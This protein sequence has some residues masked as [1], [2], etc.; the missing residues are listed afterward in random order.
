MTVSKIKFKRKLSNTYCWLPELEKRS[1][2]N[3]MPVNDKRHPR[4]PP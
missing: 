4:I 3:E 1:F 2:W